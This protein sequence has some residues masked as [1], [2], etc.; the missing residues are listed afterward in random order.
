MR[1]TAA[2]TEETA[3]SG[4]LKLS[5]DW[6]EPGTIHVPWFSKR[7]GLAFFS[8]EVLRPR[9][10]PFYLLRELIRGQMSRIVKREFD[11]ERKGLVIP[12][13]LRK[14]IRTARTR[15]VRFLTKD[16]SDPDYDT[17]GVAV[18]ESLIQTSH[19]LLDQFLEQSL[20]ARKVQTSVYPVFLGGRSC[21]VQ[22][23]EQFTKTFPDYTDTFQVWNPGYTWRH[24]E[25]EEGK[26]R[27]DLLDRFVAD[28]HKSNLE[29]F[30][31]P[32][33]RWE[34]DSLPDWLADCLD[35]PYTIRQALFR[36]SDALIRRYSPQVSK[37]VVASGLGNEMDHILVQKRIEWADTM[38]RQIQEFNPDAQALVAVERPWGD[39]LRFKSEIPPL[40]LAEA[41][42]RKSFDG[43]LISL[44]FGLVPEASLPRD[45]FDLNLLLDQWSALGKPLCFSFSI[46]SAPSSFDP[47]WEVSADRQEP[48]WSLRTQQENV[49]RYFLSFLTRKTVRGIFWNRFNDLIDPIS[50]VLN[51]GEADNSKE[52]TKSFSDL[53]EDE[54][55]KR[56]SGSDGEPILFEGMTPSDSDDDFVLET[57]DEDLPPAE[58]LEPAE[59]EI[60][61]LDDEPD[62]VTL[63]F[64]HSGLI[65]LEGNPKPAFRKLTALKS[66]YLG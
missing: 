65:D 46:P 48:I 42:M 36:Y 33:V 27:W 9:S 21:Q 13:S 17:K 45:A 20:Y 30:F 54:E 3:D 55:T 59:L 38:A 60:A 1:S 51:R 19:L 5:V 53:S 40:E 12:E 6:Q 4:I 43:F 58:I 16:P 41:L 62:A 52:A 32:I 15:M 28:A 66:A 18:F 25:P 26:F 31:G 61:S 50:E 8:T 49:N 34:R 47:D 39:S 14:A 23:V 63:G 7:F 44:D 56:R 35:E 22:H 57:D 10:E 24:I 2:F 11:W 64:P 29:P 37:W